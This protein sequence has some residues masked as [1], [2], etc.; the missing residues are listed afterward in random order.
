MDL[1]LRQ[2]IATRLQNIGDMLVFIPALRRLREGAPEARITLLGKHKQGLEIVGR[3]PYIDEILTIESRG[4]LEKLRLFREFR[5]RSPDLF[6]VSPQDQG[7]APWAVCGGAKK[8]AAFKQ[9]VQRGE[10]KREKLPFL[11]DVAPDFDASLSETEN[12]VALVE[13]A[14]KASG[15]KL[16]TKGRKALLALE[17]SWFLPD[18]E[19]EVEKALAS[20]PLDRS[21]PLVASAMFSKAPGKNWPVERFL[22][23]YEWLAKSLGAQTL[24][25][26]GE[27]DR[28]A[29][30]EAAAKAGGHVFNLAGRLSLDQSAWL[31]KR[32]ALYI[33]NDSGPT[34]LASA[35]GTPAVAFYRRE[36]YARWRHPESLAPRVELVAESD[37][38]QEISLDSAKAACEK[39]LSKETSDK[40]TP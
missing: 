10:V 17:Y 18:T 29:G 22:S 35:V 39:A 31:M 2:I 15:A 23:A 7:K 33:G 13:E 20:L 34:H 12:S 16:P 9:V 40:G 32:C 37:D 1:S 26:G 21:R 19:A 30:D 5:R 36:N 6:I 14:L 4:I 3:C 8:I 27:K 38:L 28:E 11:I 24:L 25:L